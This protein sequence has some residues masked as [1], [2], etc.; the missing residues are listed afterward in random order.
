MA[1]E[2]GKP[3]VSGVAGI[4]SKLKDGMVVEVDGSTGIIKI[5]D[6]GPT[7]TTAKVVDVLGDGSAAH[8]VPTAWGD[9]E[10]KEGL[11]M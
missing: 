2:F 9:E 4:A 1:R 11:L 10:T 3:C 8:A 7:A 5:L 6:D